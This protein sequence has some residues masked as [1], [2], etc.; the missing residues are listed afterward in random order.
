[1]EKD[2]PEVARWSG[3]TAVYMDKLLK[4]GVSLHDVEE[5]AEDW[6]EMQ[7]NIPEYYH[8]VIIG[9]ALSM[10]PFPPQKEK[11]KNVWT[12]MAQKLRNGRV[13]LQRIWDTL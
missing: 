6:L 8:S 3:D 10:I 1:M 11:R 7:P 4:E 5:K 13:R 2:G 9:E 12:V